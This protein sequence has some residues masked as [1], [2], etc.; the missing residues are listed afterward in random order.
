MPEVTLDQV[1][2][3]QVA[4]KEKID[5]IEAH[6]ERLND[7][8]G[9]ME[10]RVAVIEEWKRCVGEPSARDTSDLKV[11][12]AKLVTLGASI[13]SSGSVVFLLLKNVFA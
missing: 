13:G 11:T 6:L 5:K 7:R 8:V 10:V 3:V 1:Y 4:S 2:A 12:V 9:G